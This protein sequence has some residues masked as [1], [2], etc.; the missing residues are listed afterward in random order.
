MLLD[1]KVLLLL[2]SYDKNIGRKGRFE[3]INAI[4]YCTCVTDDVCLT[5]ACTVSLMGIPQTHISF[6]QLR[7]DK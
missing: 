4:I 1:F 2:S 3:I 7:Y 5:L 6:P